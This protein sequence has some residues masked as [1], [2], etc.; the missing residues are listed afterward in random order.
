MMGTLLIRKNYVEDAISI[1]TTKEVIDPNAN[2]KNKKEAMKRQKNK[3]VL[4]K[5]VLEGLLTDEMMASLVAKK[6]NPAQL[7]SSLISLVLVH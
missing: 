1:I 7:R 2:S 3:K 5:G 6:A 4:V